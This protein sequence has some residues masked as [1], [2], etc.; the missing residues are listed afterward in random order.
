MM[1]KTLLLVVGAV[2]MVFAVS[3]AKATTYEVSNASSYDFYDVVGN[4]YL[5][6]AVVNN[7]LM[8]YIASNSSSG[9]VDASK[10]ANKVQVAFKFLPNGDVY[11]TVE[12]Y[13]ITRGEHTKIV[14]DDE[15]QIYGDSKVTTT[16]REARK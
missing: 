12:Y 9:P 5:G 4:E 7:A 6:T 3:C 11:T 10:G 8:G 2:L 1:K 15:T 16:I 14:L 13:S